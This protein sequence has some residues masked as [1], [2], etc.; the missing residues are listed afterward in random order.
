L[1]FDLS[2]LGQ[3]YG[4]KIFDPRIRLW[5]LDARREAA[6]SPD[7][8]HLLS[9]GFSHRF[10]MSANGNVVLLYTEAYRSEQVE[11]P[12]YQLYFFEMP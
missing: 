6:T 4:A 7:L 3:E 2:W 10:R 8:L 11:K 5:D 12:Q 1:K 9:S